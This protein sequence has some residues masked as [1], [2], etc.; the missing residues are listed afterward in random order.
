MKSFLE[1]N[2]DADLWR[3]VSKY[4]KRGAS[5]VCWLA[6]ADLRT[7][8]GVES[9]ITLHRGALEGTIVEPRGGVVFSELSWNRA[10]LPVGHDRTFGEMELSE[11]ATMSHRCK[12][13]QSL[14]ASL[15]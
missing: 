11:Q 8:L 3:L 4:E 6:V 7:G 9:P 2:N 14:V 10:F 5:C 1:A 12:A 15:K 13:L